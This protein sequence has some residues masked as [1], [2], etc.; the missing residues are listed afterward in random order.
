MLVEILEVEVEVGHDRGSG[1]A[2][3]RN[4]LN[5]GG[6]GGKLVGAGRRQGLT[7]QMTLFPEPATIIGGCQKALARKNNGGRDTRFP[8]IHNREPVDF[9]S[10]TILH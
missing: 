10:M 8:W 2:Y 7:N 1:F 5:D 3:S 4:V 6:T 9:H